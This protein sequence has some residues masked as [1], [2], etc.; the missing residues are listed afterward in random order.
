MESGVLARHLNN[1]FG[2]C[3][4]YQDNLNLNFGVGSLP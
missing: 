2:N 4:K 3:D 1:E